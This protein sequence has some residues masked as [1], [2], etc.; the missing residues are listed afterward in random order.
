MDLVETCV[1][2]AML[3]ALLSVVASAVKEALEAA[4]QK[5]KQN[6][7]MAIEELL[8]SAG[9]QAFLDHPRI[10]AML[11]KTGDADS[12]KARHWPTY[13]EAETFAVVANELIQLDP[14]GQLAKAVEW[15]EKA[16]QARLDVIEKVYQERMERL[17][18]SFKRHAQAW[19]MGIGFLLACGVDADTIQMA[20]Q[21]GNDAPAREALVK[22][23]DNTKSVDD[24]AKLCG[25][26]VQPAAQPGSAPVPASDIG[27]QKPGALLECMQTQVPGVIGWSATKWK[28]ALAMP[29]WHWFGKLFGFA[30]TAIA[31]SLGAAFWFDLIGKVANIRATAK[32][33]PD[34]APQ[35]A[36]PK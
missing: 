7:K 4:V 24:F 21:L 13:I 36:A 26:P 28:D 1:A 14:E 29:W 17:S 2:L 18:G 32:P 34:P 15:A 25:F 30:I 10:R 33:R 9:A 19:L 8:G 3:Y 23:A 12:D 5:R 11:S 20:R 27:L 16:G 35:P 31:I 22:L 6:F